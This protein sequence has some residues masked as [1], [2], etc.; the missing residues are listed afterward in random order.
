MLLRVCKEHTFC[1]VVHETY[2]CPICDSIE[3]TDDEL[4][5]YRKQVEE[6]EGE[7]R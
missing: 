7:N 1:V 6:L 2:S 4:K 5:A 3:Y